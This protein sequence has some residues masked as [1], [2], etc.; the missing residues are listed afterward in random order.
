[1]K[2][3]C[4]IVLLIFISISLNAQI[5]T[6]NSKKEGK[7]I[8]HKILKTPNYIIE[9]QYDK[10]THYFIST[11]GGF[12]EQSDNSI[13]C[14]LEFNS[15][16][17]KDNLKSVE[18][19]I[20]NW[21]LS[22][23]TEQAYEGLWLMAGRVNDKGERR[24]DITRPRKTLKLLIDGHFQ[25]TAFNTSTFEFFGAGGGVYTSKDG[26]YVEH[27]EY[28]SRDNSK[29]GKVLSFEYKM[30]DNDWY[31]KGLNSSGKPLHEIW[32]KRKEN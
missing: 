25:W 18:W 12:Y 20:T 30:K 31:H 23:S 4:L 17:S 28:F 14:L 5:Y 13:K 7:T 15:N 21:K 27:I 11:R 8:E 6:F 22:P 9:T 32:T 10:E 29:F 1:M 2:K 24:R 16:Y 26:N 19:V 3:H